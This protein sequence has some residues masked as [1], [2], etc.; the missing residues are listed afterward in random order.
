MH[1]INQT[2]VKKREVNMIKYCLKLNAPHI[3][4]VQG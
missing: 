1:T 3:I 4:S 2:N